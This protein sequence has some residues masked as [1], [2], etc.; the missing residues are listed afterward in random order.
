MLD[1]DKL[2]KLPKYA[3]DEIARL[4]DQVATLEVKNNWLEDE[5]R[6][7]VEA[8]NT[9][10]AEGLHDNTALPPF[11]HID[12]FITDGTADRRWKSA[13]TVRLNRDGQSIH[14]SGTDSLLVSPQASNVVNI[15]LRDA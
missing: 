8:S 7:K 3:R 6:H 14:V 12:F 1:Q 4:R 5:N 11:C 2:D 9:V 13:I 15:S 10:L